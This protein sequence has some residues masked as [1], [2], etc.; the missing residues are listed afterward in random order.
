MHNSTFC[1]CSYACG[2]YRYSRW[3]RLSIKIAK[4]LA[5]KRRKQNSV[6]TALTSPVLCWLH[7]SDAHLA[8]MLGDQSAS[9]LATSVELVMEA[10]A[11]MQVTRDMPGTPRATAVPPR[12]R[13]R[14]ML[15]VVPNSCRRF[16]YVHVSIY[17]YPALARAPLRAAATRV[18]SLHCGS[19][20]GNLSPCLTSSPLI[21]SPLAQHSRVRAPR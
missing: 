16:A 10:F 1:Y 14:R 4:R 18:S 21:G 15:E 8:G 7:S 11:A 20:A 2:W 17:D 5:K 19:N 3:S 9:T 12:L 13:A 6:F